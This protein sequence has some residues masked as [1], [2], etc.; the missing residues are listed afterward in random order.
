VF[1]AASPTDASAIVRLD[2]TT[3]SY[4]ILRRSLE[5]DVDRAYVSTPRSIA[6]PTDDG[7]VA[8]ALYYPPTNAEY[9]GPAGERPPLIVKSHGGPTSQAQ[10]GLS[11]DIQYWTSRGFGVVD[12]NYG[13]SSG[14]GRAY[15]ERLKGRWG[16]VDTQDCINAARYLADQGEVDGRRL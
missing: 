7:A 4:A 5:H 15:R 13:G 6:F 1:L 3:G 16:I 9:V 2:A 11:L 10:A 12:V 14:F 8:Y